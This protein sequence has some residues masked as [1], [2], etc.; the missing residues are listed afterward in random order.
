[1]GVRADVGVVA[2]LAV[3]TDAVLDHDPGSDHAVDQAGVGPDLTPVADHR[4]ALQD[5]A[6][7]QR[8]IATELH[9]DVDE[10]LARVEHRHPVE[11]PVA[12]GAAAQLAF[13]ERKLPPVVDTAGLRLGS[14]NGADDLAT[15]QL[16][17]RAR[18]G[19][20]LDATRT[21]QFV[22]ESDEAARTLKLGDGDAHR[23]DIAYATRV[24]AF[25]FAME[26]TR[27][28]TR[29]RLDPAYRV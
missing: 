11:E 21:A 3:A 8:D 9:G 25:D 5:R 27:I 24:D 4:V 12:V 22:A 14:M 16:I 19:D 17:E 2:H 26:V 23:D 7:I 20:N 6:G 10:R 15:A 13:G 1:M 18:V 29:L 28:G